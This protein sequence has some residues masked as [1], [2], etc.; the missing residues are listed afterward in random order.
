MLTGLDGGEVVRHVG[1]EGGGD[2]RLDDGRAVDA[3]EPEEAH[4]AVDDGEAEVAVGGGEERLE[5]LDDALCEAEAE[6]GAEDEVEDPEHEDTDGE[7]DD[8]LEGLGDVGR[9]LLGHL[10]RDVALDE[11]LIDDA[12]HERGDEGREQTLGAQVGGVEAA[13]VL[14]GDRVAREQQEADDGRAHARDE[15]DLV[16]L[17]EVAVLG[18]GEVLGRGRGA[19]DGQDAHGVVVALPQGVVDVIGPVE[20]PDV[21]DGGHEAEDGREDDDGDDRDE[22]IADGLQVL[23]ARDR[24][25]E[26]LALLDRCDELLH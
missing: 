17:G 7:G 4:G 2:G 25:E 14:R 26:G 16:V 1:D 11:E 13:G 8:V 3:H 10:D 24:V 12:R 22:A 20:T 9:N 23:V 6:G 21:G 18:V 5:D 19:G 15:V